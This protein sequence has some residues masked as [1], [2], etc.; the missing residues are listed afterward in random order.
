MALYNY[1]RFHDPFEFGMSY[2]LTYFHL[3]G[4]RICGLCSGPEVRSFFRLLSLYLLARPKF[5][6]GFPFVDLEHHALDP[7][8]SF[9]DTSDQVVGV[10]ALVPLAALGTT[11]A[12]ILALRRISDPASRAGVLVTFGGWLSLAGLASC[13]F[14]S[15]RYELDFMLLV[16]AG[17]AVCLERATTRGGAALRW[18]GSAL[19]LYSILVG[20]LL[21]F[22]GTLGEFIVANPE[23][24]R[25]LSAIFG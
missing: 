3:A 18:I 5:G 21:G 17:A 16:V 11:A 6:G 15:A 9:A 23:L 19:A 14:A 10:V 13:A 22:R 1:A 4:R 8:V 2:Q 25:R 7:R 24:H 20:L 12:V